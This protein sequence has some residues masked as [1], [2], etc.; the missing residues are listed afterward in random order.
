MVYNKNAKIPKKIYITS[1][2]GATFLLTAQKPF[3]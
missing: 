1:A 3:C 2:L